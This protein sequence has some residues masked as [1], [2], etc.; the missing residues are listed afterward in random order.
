M[1]LH[2]SKSRHQCM[3][4]KKTLEV[5]NVLADVALLT[6]L[7]MPYRHG[8]DYSSFTSIYIYPGEYMSDS[9]MSNGNLMRSYNSNEEQIVVWN[10]A[11]M[12]VQ[13]HFRFIFCLYRDQRQRL[14]PS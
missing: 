6:P 13:E 8:F 11:S 1:T 3:A 2:R 5:V 4:T 10:L 12:T 7:A 14:L 9:W